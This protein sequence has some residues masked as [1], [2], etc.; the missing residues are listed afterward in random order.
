[1]ENKE[2]RLSEM[3]MIINLGEYHNEGQT[4]FTRAQ[5][6]YLKQI[7]RRLSLNVIYV[8]ALPNSIYSR[9]YLEFKTICI[10]QSLS[11]RE[12]L[13]TL[14]FQLACAIDASLEEKNDK[15]TRTPVVELAAETLQRSTQYAFLKVNT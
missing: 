6:E 4:A 5:L 2:K 15:T 1:M 3:L 12:I 11:D 13:R 8:H 10:Q 7:A 14:S 9:S